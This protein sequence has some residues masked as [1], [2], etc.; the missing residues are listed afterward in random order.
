MAYEKAGF[1]KIGERRNWGYWLGERVNEVLM[2][3]FVGPSEVKR[4]FEQSP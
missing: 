4:R 2:E 3:D 1:R